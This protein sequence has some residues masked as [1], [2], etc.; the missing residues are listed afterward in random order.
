M[1]DQIDTW[2]AYLE[3]VKAQ[4]MGKSTTKAAKIEKAGSSRSLFG[5]GAKKAPPP[6]TSIKLSYAD[7][8]KKNV[9][10][11]SEIPSSAQSA[12]SFT[13]RLSPDVP[14]MFAVVVVFR[15]FEAHRTTLL[16]ED[17]LGEQER[18]RENLEMDNVTLNVN[19]LI[20]LLNTSFSIM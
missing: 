1:N 17:L 16:L 2:R 7:L 6:Q 3:N 10:V 12:V 15:G 18:G 14:G 4:A 13:F 5:I 8:V 11:R 20:H 9:I 19:M